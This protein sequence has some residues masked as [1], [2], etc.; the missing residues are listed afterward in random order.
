MK[1]IIQVF[2]NITTDYQVDLDGAG[3]TVINKAVK[4]VLSGNNEL[5]IDTIKNIFKPGDLRNKPIL[6]K[7][8]SSV[9]LNN[10]GS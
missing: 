2:N 8:T 4:E 1:S 10:Q 9:A 7:I 3:E 5:N 6:E